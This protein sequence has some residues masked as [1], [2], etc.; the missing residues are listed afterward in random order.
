M[1]PPLD[2]RGKSVLV[3]GGTRGVGRGIA[4]C[5]LAAG[6]E[7]VICGRNAPESLPQG[8]RN[9]ARFVAADVRDPEQVDRFLEV[10]VLQ[11]DHALDLLQILA[12]LGRRVVDDDDG[13]GAG[14]PVERRG[15]F[16]DGV[17]QDVEGALLVLD[18][19]PNV[20]VAMS[21]AKNFGLYRE[22]VGALYVKAPAAARHAVA[23]NLAAIARA[24]YSM[25][26]D[27]GAACVRTILGDAALS[28]M[29]RSELDAI[30]SQMKATRAALAAARINSIP[31]HLIGAQKG[32]FS[33]LPLSPAQI[34]TLRAENGIYMTG[35]GRINVAGLR[36]GE[37]AR[38][39]DAVA[40]VAQVPR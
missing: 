8:N 36:K 30:R 4:Q 31:M 22:R 10:D 15:R 2:F 23:S 40:A 38:V 9:S 35:A 17:E 16:G 29:W 7:V 1:R 20:I 27:H 28:A 25:P 5:F 21:C 26:P 32:M 34:E 3:T 11:Q 19:V 39:I 33:T 24:N 13:R 14:D 12:L 37:I 18:R 6:A